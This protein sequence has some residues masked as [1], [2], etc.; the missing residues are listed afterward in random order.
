MKD[1]D[2]NLQTN[3]LFPGQVNL[4]SQN[5]SCF[6]LRVAFFSCYYLII[7]YISKIKHDLTI[8]IA[9]QYRALGLQQY[10]VF[11]CFCYKRCSCLPNRAIQKN[12][13]KRKCLLPIYNIQMERDIY[14]KNTQYYARERLEKFYLS[15][16]QQKT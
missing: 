16:V 1:P 15:G 2:P 10:H 11:F 9:L 4:S 13:N 7:S 3:P 14:R 6:L 5:K 8:I 12:N